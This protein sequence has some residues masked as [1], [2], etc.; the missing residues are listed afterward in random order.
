MRQGMQPYVFEREGGADRHVEQRE[1]R[2]PLVCG[3]DAGLR[4]ER[5]WDRGSC[6]LGC[7]HTGCRLDVACEGSSQHRGAVVSIVAVS[8]ARA[9]Y[10]Q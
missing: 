2:V 6:R 1:D 9:A 5:T 3:L 7:T 10:L 4:R 8:I